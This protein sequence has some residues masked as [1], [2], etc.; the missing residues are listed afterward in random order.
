ML[1]DAIA[2]R[3]AEEIQPMPIGQHRPA[4]LDDRQDG[5][6]V[7]DHEPGT[8][9]WRRFTVAVLSVLP[10]SGCCKAGR[11]AYGWGYRATRFERLKT[12]PAAL[13]ELTADGSCGLGQR[14]RVSGRTPPISSRRRAR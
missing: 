14:R 12:G 9:T 6:V 10:S 8:G 1:A 2:Q 4:T 7:L 11:I 3:F 13:E 5:G